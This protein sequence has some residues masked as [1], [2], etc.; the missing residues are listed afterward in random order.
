MNDTF[1]DISMAL[2][3]LLIIHIGLG[4]QA[5]MDVRRQ[6][7][8]L[9]NTGSSPIRV[10]IE[11]RGLFG[12]EVNALY[13]I[14]IETSH[15]ALNRP[16]FY[17]YPKS[18]WKGSIRHLFVKLRDVT[19][20]GYP[21]REFT[22]DIPSLT[23]DLGYAYYQGRLVVRDAG[24]GA[25]EIVLSS[26]DL[27]DFIAKKYQG[28]FSNFSVAILPHG[29]IRLSGELNFLGEQLPVDIQAKLIIMTP[30]S[31]GLTAADVRLNGRPL[32]VPQT[33]LLLSRIN[34]VVDLN[35]DLGIGDFF[36]IEQLQYKRDMLIV[37][38]DCRLST[39]SASQHP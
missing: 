10:N 8:L 4:R 32:D 7:A 6:A 13:S 24:R 15:V 28:L 14:S 26:A 5:Y 27:H 33:A 1:L 29:D 18:G 21:V 3:A 16:P 22:A 36:M 9:F 2:L 34:P 11:P 25:G 31:V 39:A 30:T 38:G 35:S 37:R 23:Y 17:L 12:F 20:S 19:V